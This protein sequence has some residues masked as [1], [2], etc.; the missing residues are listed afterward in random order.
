M[1]LESD[2]LRARLVVPEADLAERVT[3]DDRAVPG[4][5]GA[6]TRGPSAVGKS[7]PRSGQMFRETHLRTP[8]HHT[9]LRWPR[10]L[11]PCLAFS[12]S[13]TMRSTTRPVL[14]S[15]L[16]RHES[17]QPVTSQLSSHCSAASSASLSSSLSTA[18]V[19][20][21][22]RTVFLGGAVGGPQAIDSKRAL[23]RSNRR[24]WTR[25]PSSESERSRIEP[26]AQPSASSVCAG[27]GATDQ[28]VPDWVG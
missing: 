24:K 19:A 4:E 9:R 15:H 20:A 7:K 21:A 13:T 14:K 25:S 12:R 27:L 11:A 23:V 3:R 6:A 10:P 17:E 22:G 1:R 8:T 5:V 26:S 16:R 18:A 2:G 28:S